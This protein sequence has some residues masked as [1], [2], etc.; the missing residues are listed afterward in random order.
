MFSLKE[1]GTDIRTELL[2]GLFILRFALL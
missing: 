1:H 2:A